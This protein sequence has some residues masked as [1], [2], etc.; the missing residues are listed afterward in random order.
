MGQ[1]YTVHLIYILD[2]RKVINYINIVVVFIYIY[3]NS[4]DATDF[5]GRVVEFLFCFFNNESQYCVLILQ[6]GFW[7]NVAKCQ[8]RLH[9]VGSRRYVIVGWIMVK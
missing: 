6:E 3:K 1:T 4:V 5:N 7:K 9:T 8:R 2:E